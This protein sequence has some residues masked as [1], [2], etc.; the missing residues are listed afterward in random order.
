[1]VEALQK[2]DAEQRPVLA[3]RGRRVVVVDDQVTSG[4]NLKK[5]VESLRSSQYQVEGAVVWSASRAGMPDQPDCALSEWQGRRYG[6]H[7]VVCRQ[8]TS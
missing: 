7:P 8:H 6:T 2:H 5:A 4:T 3:G 1:V